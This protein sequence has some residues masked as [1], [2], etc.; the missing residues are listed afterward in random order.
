MHT[1]NGWNLCR[2]N[3]MHNVNEREREAIAFMNRVEQSDLT[4]KR[5]FGKNP[6]EAPLQASNP[7]FQTIL[8]RLIFG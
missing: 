7:E 6:V 1:P 8:N 4:Y 5:L 2:M 3:S